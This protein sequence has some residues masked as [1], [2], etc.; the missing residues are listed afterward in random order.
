[1]L[2]Q[3]LLVLAA[4]IAFVAAQD[5][6][7][8]ATTTGTATPPT[9]TD[10]IPACVLTCSLQAGQAAGCTF[11]DPACAC[12]TTNNFQAAAQE[13]LLS[14]CTPE[15]QQTA[16]GL[17]AALCG[18]EASSVIPSASDSATGS[19]TTEAESETSSSTS[20]LPTSV[21]LPTTSL[22]APT[23]T[24]PVSSSTT[25]TS[26]GTTA[27]QQ[28]TSNAALGGKA[29]VIGTQ[30]FVAAGVAVVGAAMGAVFVL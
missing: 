16:L 21:S 29:V 2:A 4:S 28:T 15:E 7:A 24:R 6:S 1:M 17:Q 11:S 12:S 30:G 3:K 9:S 14:Q 8:P 5:S 25:G 26:S 22:P 27:P 19:A 10:G 20:A 23:V 13:C 18:G